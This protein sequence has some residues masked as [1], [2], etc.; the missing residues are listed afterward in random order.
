MIIAFMSSVDGVLLACL[1]FRDNPDSELIFASDVGE[2]KGKL[3]LSGIEGEINMVGF[4]P[5]YRSESLSKEIFGKSKPRM[6]RF[7]PDPLRYVDLL[8]RHKECDPA[9]L[10]RLLVSCNGD[11]DGLYSGKGKIAKRYYNYMREVG[12][13]YERLCMF[14]RPELKGGI[15]SVVIDTPHDIADMFC[16]WLVR[17]NPDVPVAVIKNGSAWVGNG[18]LIGLDRFAKITASFVESLRSTSKS[19]DVDELWDL[20]YNSQMIDSRRNHGLAKKMQPKSSASMSKMSK[21]DRYKVERGI[22]GCT[23]DSFA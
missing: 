10:V 7:D 2:L 13:A 23:L 19:D 1:A 20:Y 3:D 5:S 17:K 18:D 21:R 4:D 14:A 12:K 16:R 11:T 6:A 22:A 15:L 8:L 9:G